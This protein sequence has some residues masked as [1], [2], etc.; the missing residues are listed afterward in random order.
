MGGYGCT[1][2]V[3]MDQVAQVRERIDIISLLSEFLPLKKAGRNFKTQCPFHGEKTPSFVVSPERQ[4]WHCFGCHKGGD[5]FT[6]LMEYENLEFGEALRVLAKRAGITLERS[7]ME[8]GLSSKKDIFYELN[9]LAAEFY[10]Y[11]LTKHSVGK[12]A[13]AYVIDERKISVPVVNTFQLG[14]APK[15]G[16]ALV[17]YLLKKKH[18]RAQDLIDSGLANKRGPQLLDFFSDRLIFPLLNHRGDVIGFSGRLLDKNAPAHIGKYVNTRETLVYHKGDV[19]FGLHIAKQ[20]IKKENKAIIMEGEFDVMAAFQEGISNAVAIK[21]TA[22]T[23]NQV[24]LISRFCETIDLCFD[25]DKAGIEAMKR[26]I[27]LLEKK[28]LTASVILLPEGKD[29]HDLLTSSP[30][31]FKKALKEAVGVYDYLLSLATASFDPDTVDGK[32]QI[33]NEL[34]PVYR[35]IENEIIKEHYLRKL[36][37]TIGTSYESVI[38]QLGKGQQAAQFVKKITEPVKQ[39][40]ER[41]EMLEEYLL[42]LIIQSEHPKKAMD[43]ITQTLQG[44]LSKERAYQKI[45]LH[46]LSHFT[47]YEQFDSKHF[48]SALPSELLSTYDTGFVYPLPTFSDEGKYLA[49]VTKIANA[50]K[51]SYV[52]SRLKKLSEEIKKKEGKTEQD[53][54]LSKLQDEFAKL[55]S[56][57][58]A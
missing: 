31:V 26:S 53:D 19:F 42:A 2:P 18:Y 30:G 29:P 21:G 20:A 56:Q 50:L 7:K 58:H 16:N 3:A 46:L 57:L 8:K 33:S 48:G 51:V 49:E 10:H 24:A 41:E 38:R 11:V 54:E 43:V 9:H 32:R 17:N 6:F 47:Q 28:G 45:L 34:L 12:K 25:Q 40:R 52:K 15:S 13:L 35:G 39:K 27:P 44:V 1:I 14:F 55:S 37:Q 4:I 36:A 23:E 22:L 5:V